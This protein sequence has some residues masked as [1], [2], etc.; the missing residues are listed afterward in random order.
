MITSYITPRNEY[1][2]FSKALA[3][4]LLDAVESDRGESSTGRQY[5]PNRPILKASV[6]YETSPAARLFAAIP[7]GLFGRAILREVPAE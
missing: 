7:P 3:T 2:G 6:L 4:K 1:E 5:A